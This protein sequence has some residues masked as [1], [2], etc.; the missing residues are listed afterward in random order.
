MDQPTSCLSHVLIFPFPVQGHVN[1]M[2]KL[3]QLLC[4]EGL[5]VTFL[6]SDFIHRR[7]LSY[8]NI[9]LSY[10]QYPNLYFETIPDGLPDDHPRTGDRVVDLFNSI[11]TVTKPRFMEML[12]A[13]RFSI[14]DRPPLTCII[15][16]GIMCFTIDIGR[17]LNIPTILFR[18][19]SAS[20]FWA[21]FCL[22]RLIE[23]GE[24]PITGQS[25]MDTLLT[26][27]VGMETFLRL[28]DLPSF[29]RASDLTD[30]GLQLVISATQLTKSA[31]GLIL[32]TFEELEGPALAQITN[33][34]SKLYTIG[35]LHVQLK[36]RVATN[37]KLTCTSSSS[38]WEEDRSCIVWLDQQPFKSVIYVSFGSMTVLTRDQFMEFLHGFVNSG[39][40]FLWVVR[41]KSVAEDYQIPEE[42]LEGTRQRGYIVEWA[43]QEEVL[44]HPAIGGFL[45]HSGW[46]STLESIYEGVPMICWPFYADQQV[47]SRLVGEVWKIGLDMKD[48][49]DRVIIENMVKD[50]IET[51]KDEFAKSARLMTKLARKSVS[52]NGS[53]YC[54]LDRLIKDIKLM[55]N[56]N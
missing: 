4:R 28:R 37:I 21:F 20:C 12:I 19:I 22:P 7:L 45:T 24:L 1:C 3:A 47:N 16:D 35:P 13:R 53:S 48:T 40:P 50:L 11:D 25:D 31:H 46:N 33:N 2:L 43:P 6:N 52:E 54:N 41:P 44:A 34:I 51:R 23:A 32:N 42:L 56:G 36:A 14:L 55:R 9:H 30:R 27:V 49:C 38:L 18:T 39:K 5:H 17:E 10:K 8:T 29:C 26:N 15:A